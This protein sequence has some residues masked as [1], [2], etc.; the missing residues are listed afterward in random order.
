[1]LQCAADGPG[2]A[3]EDPATAA[4][5]CTP[6]LVYAQGG[7]RPS[8]THPPNPIL[9]LLPSITRSLLRSPYYCFPTQPRPLRPGPA[10]PG[11]ALRPPPRPTP[12]AP[13]RPDPA[14]RPPPRSAPHPAPPPAV[15]FKFHKWVQ[16]LA[17]LVAIAGFLLGF[18]IRGW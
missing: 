7:R 17:F 10:R 14:L 2:Q 4:A 12:S 9:P 3:W 16:S 13:A 15:W 8:S 11:L 18:S 5:P 6:C 1:M